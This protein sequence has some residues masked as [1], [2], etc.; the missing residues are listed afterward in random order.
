MIRKKGDV[1]RIRLKAWMDA[2]KKDTYGTIR[3]PGD[4]KYALAKAMQEY[5]RKLAVVTEVRINSYDLDIDNGE[6]HWEDWMFEDGDAADTPLPSKEAA[7]AMLDGETLYDETGREYFWHEGLDGGV[8]VSINRRDDEHACCRAHSFNDLYRRP[9]KRTRPMTRWEIIN[10]A[11]SEASRGWVVWQPQ[12]GVWE[13]P[14]Y[15]EYNLD[16]EKYQRARLLPDL[17]GVDESTIQDFE[18]EEI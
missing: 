12:E 8:F 10:W 15:F 16:P 4:V 7:R 2:Q 3:V 11:N 13:S 17:S 6:H 5:A 9:V 14:Q 18:V 1:V